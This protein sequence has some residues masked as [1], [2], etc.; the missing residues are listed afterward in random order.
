[1]DAQVR[2]EFVANFDDYVHKSRTTPAGQYTEPLPHSALEHSEEERNAVYEERW[3]R[4]RAIDLIAVYPPDLFTNMDANHT[5]SEFFRGK[6]RSKV[7]DPPAL[8]ETLSPPRTYPLGAKRMT[9]NTGYFETYNR[10][11]VRLVDLRQDPLLEFTE[12][13]IRTESGGSTSSTRSSSPPA[14]TR[15][16]A[17]G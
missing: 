17:P 8:A 11:N 7:T 15:S 2:D 16:P 4:H 1:M 13:G 3:N 12:T 14:S 5:I 9:L 10:E 6:I